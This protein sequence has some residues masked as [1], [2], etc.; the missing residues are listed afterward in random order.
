MNGAGAR[1]GGF[2]RLTEQEQPARMLPATVLN[3]EKSV[4]E[5][6]LEHAGEVSR[7]VRLS[8]VEQIGCVRKG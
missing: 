4:L 1:S 8:V 3:G 2:A 6:M 5:D 7:V